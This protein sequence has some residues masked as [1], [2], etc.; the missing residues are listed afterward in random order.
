R[1]STKQSQHP[2]QIIRHQ[3]ESIQ[4]QARILRW[5]LKPAPMDHIP[6][7][8]EDYAIFFHFSENACSPFCANSYEVTGRIRIV[9]ASKPHR[10]AMMNGGIV[11][12]LSRR[13]GA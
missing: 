8:A 3:H 7:V 2:M 10:S 9:V 13:E 5:Q 4:F 6:N 11:S 12:H 1:V